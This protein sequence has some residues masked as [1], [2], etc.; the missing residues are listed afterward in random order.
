MFRNLSREEITKV[1]YTGK[2]IFVDF[3]PFLWYFWLKNNFV[4]YLAKKYHP[5]VLRIFFKFQI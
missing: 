1:A 4:P 5:Q 2:Y 3:P